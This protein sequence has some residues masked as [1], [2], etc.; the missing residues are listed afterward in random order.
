[1]YP[2]CGPIEV[3]GP[4]DITSDGI[5]TIPICVDGQSGIAVGTVDD[6]GDLLW[7]GW[8]TVPG[9]FVPGVPPA[10]STYGACPITVDE[11]NIDEIDVTASG[12]YQR[13]FC[14]ADGVVTVFYCKD[15]SHVDGHGDD[16][17][18]GVLDV[19]IAGWV[20]PLD[21]TPQPPETLP[22]VLPMEDCTACADAAFFSTTADA[23]AQTGVTTLSIVNSTCCELTV[24]TSIGDIVIPP[25]MCSD[26]EPPCPLD[27]IS[28][29]F[30]GDPTDCELTDVRV[31]GMTT[32]N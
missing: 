31:T 18:S 26:E 16:T 28:A 5:A 2:N 23:I 22:A 3:Q 17:D 24:T 29:A 13:D 14:T 8:S 4:I 25:F 19:T 27:L 11:I 6:A 12:G 1:M 30:S 7:T 20:G 15:E 9:T 21:P 10:G 32:S